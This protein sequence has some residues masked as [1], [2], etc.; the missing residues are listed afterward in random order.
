MPGNPT[1]KGLRDCYAAEVM[2]ELLVG[3]PN[4]RELK[5]LARCA[6]DI[7]DAML[8]GSDRPVPNPEST[9]GVRIGG[10]LKAGK[11]APLNL[12]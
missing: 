11:G 6:F 10:V 2:N 9:E 7:A 8:E 4:P 5:E 1:R 3:T 12:G